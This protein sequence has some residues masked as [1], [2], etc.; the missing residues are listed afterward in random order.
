MPLQI[1]WHRFGMHLESNAAGRDPLTAVAWRVETRHAGAPGS[2]GRMEGVSFRGDDLR[3]RHN[4][5]KGHHW[6]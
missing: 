4:V 3:E 1:V 6:A 5:R 2:D